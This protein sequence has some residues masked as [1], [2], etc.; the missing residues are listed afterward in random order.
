MW[1]CFWRH[2]VVNF[3]TNRNQPIHSSDFT[4][5]P[6]LEQKLTMSTWHIWFKD[7]LPM[8]G[9][10][11]TPKAQNS[12]LPIKERRHT[13]MFQVQRS[14]GH[15]IWDLLT[16]VVFW[17]GLRFIN[18]ESE[19]CHWPY[20]YQTALPSQVQL[21]RSGLMLTKRSGCDSWGESFR[22][23]SG[24]LFAPIQHF[25]LPLECDIG[26]MIIGKDHGVRS[27]CPK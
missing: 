23:S 6:N 21:L 5:W 8:L 14:P 13:V 7:T 15:F 10:E 1:Q 18:L 2:L 19:Y 9:G 4:W 25:P 27:P 16:K 11:K 24:Y 26:D 22:Q 12:N 3:G 17:L 20:H